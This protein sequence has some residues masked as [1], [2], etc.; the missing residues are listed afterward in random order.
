MPPQVAETVNAVPEDRALGRPRS[1][2]PI[3][4][5][6]PSTS[7]APGLAS[8]KGMILRNGPQEKPVLVAKPQQPQTQKSPWASVQPVQKASPGGMPEPS[9]MNRPFGREGQMARNYHQPYARDLP[10]DDF[11]RSGYREAPSYGH[12]ELFNPQSGRSEPVVD[13]RG[14]LRTEQT[15]YPAV[16]QR[17]AQPSQPPGP[18]GTLPSSN[19]PVPEAIGRRRGSSNVSGG[20]GPMA[21]RSGRGSEYQ[22][23]LIHI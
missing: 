4:Q 2:A 13:R 7:R 21:P 20:S 8:G 14:S 1:P 16:L 12:K 18:P 5:S 19:R 17:P 22:L 11:S 6:S 10:M 3:G 23:S 9:T 15:K